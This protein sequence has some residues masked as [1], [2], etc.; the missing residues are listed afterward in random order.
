MDIALEEKSCLYPQKALGWEWLDTNGRGGYA[1]SSVMNCHTRK[2]HGLLVAA[3]DNPA[4]RHV[5]LSKFEDSLCIGK[6]EHFFSCHQYPGFF[7]PGTPHCL[8][9]FH[10]D[11]AP[12]FVYRIGT[13]I[14]RKTVMVLFG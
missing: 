8:S 9:S 7:F 2:Y 11:P 5:M 13:M 10:T 4:G 3:L 6:E 1:S 12:R 14:L